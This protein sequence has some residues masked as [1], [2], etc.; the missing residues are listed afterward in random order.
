MYDYQDHIRTKYLFIYYAFAFTCQKEFLVCQLVIQ[1]AYFL[2]ENRQIKGYLQF[3][4]RYLSDTFCRLSLNVCILGPNNSEYLVCLSVC[5]LAYFL[6]EITQI[7]G[8]LKIWIRYLS[9]I[10]WRHSWDVGTLVPNHSEFLVC[11]SV[12]QLTY[13]LTS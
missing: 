7:L 4:K 8:Y 6:T 2:T 13:F 3:S 5:Q 11:L 12:S 10:F 9:E 1:L